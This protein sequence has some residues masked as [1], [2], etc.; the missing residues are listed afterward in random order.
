MEN[1]RRYG[2][3][4]AKAVEGVL[5]GHPTLIRGEVAA[6]YAQIALPF[7]RLPSKEQLTA[8]ASSKQ[9]A[10]RNPAVKRLKLLEAGGTLDD[11]YR[12][13]PIQVC[14]LGDGPLWIVLGGEV[15]V[16]YKLRLKK[17]L[18][19]DR[20]LWVTA[21]ANDIMAYIPSRRVLREG[22]YEGDTSRIGWGMPAKWAP[23]I[24]EKIVGKV[25]ELVKAVAAKKP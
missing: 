21:Y 4:L 1:C 3:E 15:V 7:D 19:R 24:E 11:H 23:T 6:R 16:D 18:G 14:R 13:Y 20:P 9:R 12:H 25:H 10:V 2:R 5:D 22:G 8:S 17:E